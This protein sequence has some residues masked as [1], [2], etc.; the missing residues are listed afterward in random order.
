MKAYKTR[1]KKSLMHIFFWPVLP[2]CTCG[3]T[4][5][6]RI[7]CGRPTYRICNNGLHLVTNDSSLLTSQGDSRRTIILCMC[8]AQERPQGKPHSKTSITA[9]FS[10]SHTHGFTTAAMVKEKQNHNKKEVSV[11]ATGVN[12][13]LKCLLYTV[14]LCKS[15][16]CSHLQRLW[17]SCLKNRVQRFCLCKWSAGT[18]SFK[19]NVFVAYSIFIVLQEEPPHN[20]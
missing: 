5:E 3:A 16:T 1:N 14:G 10:H 7:F 8:V 9:V 4:L 20:V 11:Q 6:L 15:E 18:Q 12:P 2:C 17:A 13:G 19:L